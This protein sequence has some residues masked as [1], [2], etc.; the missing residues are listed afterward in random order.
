MSVLHTLSV[1]DAIAKTERELAALPDIDEQHRKLMELIQTRDT[2]AMRIQRIR[3]ASTSLASIEPKTASEIVWRDQLTSWRNTLREELAAFPPEIR[4]DSIRRKRQ[5]VTLSLACV[6]Q[7]PIAEQGWV[8]ETLRLGDLMREAGYTEG[9]KIENQMYGQ[10]PWFGALP[11]VEDRIQA[12]EKRRDTAQA[13]LNAA[14]REA[15]V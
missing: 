1:D 9:V 7:G 6:E 3:S 8:L 5:N 10:L 12:L 15:S 13:Q 4:D 14:L 2:L 11:I